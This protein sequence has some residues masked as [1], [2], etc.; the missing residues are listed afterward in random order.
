MSSDP[1]SV[2]E[3]VTEHI[4]GLMLLLVAGVVVYAVDH[5]NRLNAMLFSPMPVPQ[6]V[7]KKR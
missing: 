7:K 5:I 4:A 1:L 3:Y 6:P 2:V